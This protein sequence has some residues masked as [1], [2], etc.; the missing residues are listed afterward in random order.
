MAK[1]VVNVDIDL[2]TAPI[3]QLEAELEQVNDQLK[4][5]ERG[6]EEFKS[7]AKESAKLTDALTKA[8]RAAEGFT[9]E[10]KF[11]AADGAIKVL[12]G[13]LASVVGVLGT[14]GIESEAFGDLEKKAAS[15][16]AVAIGIK[17]LSEGFKQLREST[18]FATAATQAF[19]NKTKAALIATGVG[20]FAVLVGSLVVYWEDVTKAVEKFAEKVPFVGMVIDGVKGAIN[21][22]ID[23][24][25]PVLE[26]IGILP[27]EAERAQM[28]LEEQTNENINNLKR[29]ISI[30][31]AE[32]AEAKKMFDLRKELIEE[33]IKLL[34]AK[35]DA[36]QELFDKTTELLSLEAAERKR[37][38]D[39]QVDNIERESVATVNA[40]TAKSVTML[41]TEPIVADLID[42]TTAAQIRKKQADEAEAEA[43]EEARKREIGRQEALYATGEALGALGSI[44]NQES[45]AAKALAISQ[46]VINT[47]LGVTEVLKQESTL[48]SPFDVIVKIANVATILASGFAAVRGIKSTPPSGGG[49]VS[50]AG[51]S[52]RGA[53]GQ[54]MQA[55]PTPVAAPQVPT[56]QP[57][58]QAYVISGDVTS[59]QEADARL[60]KRRSLG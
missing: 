60:S 51:G 24:F 11:L 7:M 6:T 56:V 40:L 16:I 34:E 32:G 4:G 23:A 13:S 38:A 50:P 44:M 18:V 45:A 30:A 41:E 25:R 47:Y 12:G 58:V 39:E 26:F 53:T 35:G 29:S 54:G 31:Q 59:G 55:P 46:A 14:I 3:E 42:L 43:L 21:S 20:A 10:K 48:P 17:D 19:G 22:L 1:S 33:E 27:D 15:A 36:Q 37:I 5:M 2:N 8:E 57:T 9:E 52:S 49:T 28:A